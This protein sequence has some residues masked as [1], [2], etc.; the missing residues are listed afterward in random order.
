MGL[1]TTALATAEQVNTALTYLA[2]RNYYLWHNQDGSWVVSTGGSPSGQQSGPSV[3]SAIINRL[4][5]LSETAD[6]KA[7]KA[8]QEYER[9]QAEIRE[10]DELLK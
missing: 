8:M 9:A 4:Q 3:W 10:I 6:T 7:T 5:H 1:V 2:K